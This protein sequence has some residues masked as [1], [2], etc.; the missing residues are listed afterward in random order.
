MVSVTENG[1]PAIPGYPG[2]VWYWSYLLPMELCLALGIISLNLYLYL[3]SPYSHTFVAIGLLIWFI[4]IPLFIV[5]TPLRI[6]RSKEG[7]HFT[8][9]FRRKIIP[10]E[11]IEFID[12]SIGGLP[13]NYGI[14][15]VFD[16]QN[17]PHNSGKFSQKVL[18]DLN[19]EL[20]KHRALPSESDIASPLMSRQEL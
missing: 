9:S 11:D 8:F 20:R 6:G 3:N 13:N 19:H 18:E 2:I 12:R 7:V 5:Y 10:W 16:A 17:K 4:S 1:R 15:S 14:I